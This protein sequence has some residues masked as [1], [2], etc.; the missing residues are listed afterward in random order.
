MVPLVLPSHIWVLYLEFTYYFRCIHCNFPPPY[1][2]G[3]YSDRV[4]GADG[5]YKGY[6]PKHPEDGDGDGDE[7]NDGW[8]VRTLLAIGRF[9]TKCLPCHKEEQKE[10][11]IG[12]AEQA[13]QN[14][15]PIA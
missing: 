6:T 2:W 3:I 14:Q 1:G 9:I 7:P 8:P 5:R 13:Q 15:K 10:E 12:D 11:K 4:L